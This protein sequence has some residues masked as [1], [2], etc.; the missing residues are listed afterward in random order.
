[1]AD[2][3]PTLPDTSEWFEAE[4]DEE[5]VDIFKRV[6]AVAALPESNPRFCINDG[7]VVVYVP[8]SHGVAPGHIYSTEGYREFNISRCCEYH[9]DKMFKDEDES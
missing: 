6:Q 2:E 4:T 3:K 7:E 5:R 1:M 8:F 9:F